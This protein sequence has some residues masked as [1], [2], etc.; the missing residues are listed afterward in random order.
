ML[1]ELSGGVDKRVLA[2]PK[3]PKTP[4]ALGTELAR[5][6]PLRREHGVYVI[7]KRNRKERS[8]T[9]TTRPGKHQSG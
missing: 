4:A 6:A 2:S 1:H 7:F 3:W 8:I 9:I 5:L